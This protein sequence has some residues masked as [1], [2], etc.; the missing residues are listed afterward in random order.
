MGR[1]SHH[2]ET[3]GTLKA[4]I[5]LVVQA[6]VDQQ[7]FADSGGGE[8][9][10]PCSECSFPPPL[11]FVMGKAT[12][13]EKTSTPRPSL[14]AQ[15]EDDAPPSAAR[16]IPGWL[17]RR[18]APFH[19]GAHRTALRPRRRLLPGKDPRGPSAGS[20]RPPDTQRRPAH[21]ALLFCSGRA[22]SERFPTGRSALLAPHPPPAH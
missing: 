11:P 9:R 3:C 15:A 17:A 22:A 10:N 13:G 7:E 8:K 12:S 19:P 1:K 16:S 20:E 21:Q 14:K 5:V 6:F 18:L 2:K 4:G